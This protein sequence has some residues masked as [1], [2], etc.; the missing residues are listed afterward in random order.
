MV[1][2]FQHADLTELSTSPE[3]WLLKQ[4]ADERNAKLSDGLWAENGLDM[5]EEFITLLLPFLG[6]C[7]SAGSCDIQIDSSNI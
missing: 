1:F 7:C 4:D 3:L 5:P 6:A 2:R